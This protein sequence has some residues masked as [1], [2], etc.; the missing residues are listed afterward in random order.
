MMGSLSA[1]LGHGAMVTFPWPTGQNFWNYLTDCPRAERY[2]P[3]I[4]RLIELLSETKAQHIDVIAYSCGSALL[5][6]ALARLRNLHPEADRAQLARRY[7]IDDAIF[8][9]SDVDLKTF[10][11][12]AAHHGHRLAD[13]RVLFAK[14]RR[15]V[16]FQPHR[17]VGACRTPL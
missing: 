17:G 5:A 13:H 6:Q 11:R 8:A 7:R 2:I 14:G 3:D 12:D 15:P 1:Y 4:E 10:A 16:V 9:G